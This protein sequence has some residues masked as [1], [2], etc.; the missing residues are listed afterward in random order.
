M[1]LL[2]NSALI[3]HPYLVR[4]PQSPHEWTRFVQTLNSQTVDPSAF[5]ATA[6]NGGIESVDALPSL[7]D[8][9]YPQG[10]VVFLTTNSKLYRNTDGSTWSKAVDGGDITASTVTSDAIIAGAITAAKISVSD[11]ASINAD[12]G[13]ITA[14]TIVLGSGGYV[15]SGQTAYDTGTGWYIGNDSGT[16]KFSIGNS[17][18]DK[19]TWDG[20]TMNVDGTV[21]ITTSA[22]TFSTSGNW[23]GFSV[24]PSGNIYYLDIGALVFMWVGGSSLFGTSNANNMK[25]SNLPAAITPTFKRDVLCLVLD[26]NTIYY[27]S[28]I[29]GTDNTLTFYISS[30]SGSAGGRTTLSNGN[31]TTSGNKGLPEGWSIMYAK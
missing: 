10:S 18:G 14:G 9:N 3:T 27:G 1:T 15:R 16:P 13:A 17:S 22:S 8:T 11:I 19:L 4:F 31:F 20:S 24:D 12:L 5:T 30:E 2:R 29:V 7:P 28:V 25:I 6:A 21:N 26:N 23:T